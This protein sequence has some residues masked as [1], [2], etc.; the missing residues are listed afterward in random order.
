MKVLNTH[1]RLLL[2]ILILVLGIFART[3]ELGSLPP[4]INE[5]EA[6]TGVDAF[7]LYRYGMDRNGVS[8]PV[9]MIS[10]GSGQNALPAYAM[11]PFIALGGLSPLTVRLPALISGFLT[12]VLMYFIGK[13]IAGGTFALLSMFLLAISPWHIL[14][15]RWGFEGNLLPFIF[16][17]G[18]LALLKSTEDGRWFAPAM[19]CMALCFYT[20][21][22]AYAAV[23]LFLLLVIPFLMRSRAIHWRTLLL[24][25]A[26]LLVISLPIGLF[27]LVN[28]RGWESLHLG[29]MTIPRLPAEPRYETIGAVFRRNISRNLI[30]NATE[31]LRLLWEQEDG[32]FFH[33][34]RPFGYFYTY[35]L[36]LAVLGAVIL[37]GDRSGK[38]G[39]ERLFLLFWLLTC[40]ALGILQPANI[41]R[42]NLIFIPLLFCIAALLAWISRYWRT[43]LWIA[44]G[45]LL[46]F[47]VLFNRAYHGSEYRTIAEKEFSA[48][49]LPAIAF[50]SRQGDQ[51]VCVTD[52]VNM[53]YIYVLFSQQL[54]PHKYV[55]TVQY[56]NPGGIFRQVQRLDRYS[57]G[58]KNCPPRKR[59]IYLLVDQFPPRQDIAYSESTFG[60]FTVYIPESQ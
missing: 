15:S 20:Y 25:L 31:L 49:L 60:R 21:G 37:F 52:E 19:A 53:P 14:I 51:P 10:W 33:T 39:R 29:P 57:F 16:S 4:G 56:A 50:A 12:L 44:V 48:G 24:G 35:T 34:V 42:M 59:A 43:G 28:N 32:F 30:S 54:D 11:I 47:F 8:F 40:I 36:P 58:L 5:D 41:S 46:S 26:I 3:W 18:F 9:Y 2:F 7:S 22:P 38:Q 13:R 27:L 55:P 6:S 23:P 45:L 17:A 1:R